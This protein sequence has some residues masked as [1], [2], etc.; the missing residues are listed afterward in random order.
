VGA[1]SLRLVPGGSGVFHDDAVYVVSAESLAEGRGYRLL[2]LPGA[3]AQT[4]YPILYPAVLAVG[5]TALPTLPS[6]L[7][8]MQALTLLLAGAAV[9]RG[10]LYVVRQRYAARLAALA[11]GML[12]ASAPNVLFYC[13]AT[14]SE[15][16]FALLVIVALWATDEHVR[17][18]RTRRRAL[19]GV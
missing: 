10:F 18:G 3:P 1:G 6:R 8:G 16:P 2:N 9:G 17:G 15:M 5:W 11:A 14:L 4:K 12:C 7:A 19:V 13:T